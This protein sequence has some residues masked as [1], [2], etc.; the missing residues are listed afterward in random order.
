MNYLSEEVQIDLIGSD[1]RQLRRM[2]GVA[3]GLFLGVAGLAVGVKRGG[4]I[5][6]AF[7]YV[8]ET[9][10][11]VSL[12]SLLIG[13]VAA[14]VNAARDGGLLPSWLLVLAPSTAWL[15]VY[16]YNPAQPLNTVIVV[17]IL[18]LLIVPLVGTIA[19][20]VGRRAMMRTVDERWQES[21]GPILHLLIGPDPKRIGQ[22]GVLASILF[23]GAVGGVALGVVPEVAF[24]PFGAIGEGLALGAVVTLTWLGLAAIPGYR[25]G[26]LVS[27]WVLIF[28]PVFGAL[29]TGAATDQFLGLPVLVE[30]TRWVAPALVIALVSGTIGYLL[31]A[32]IRRMAILR[33]HER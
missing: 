12:A 17:G 23:I 13:G 26:G 16:H 3:A 29:V 25:T 24:F 15:L 1:P 33:R 32:A 19:H 2:L 6:E 8:T 11:M 10:V 28:G 20:A 18:A 21:T 22:W 7:V 14:G 27:S 5:P 9:A 30:A 31:G 4:W